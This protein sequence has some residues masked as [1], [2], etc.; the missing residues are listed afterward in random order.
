MSSRTVAPVISPMASMA[1]ST[2]VSTASGVTPSCRLLK[3]PKHG[4]VGPADGVEL[5]GV[6]ENGAVAGR[7]VFKHGVN[8]VRKLVKPRPGFRADGNDIQ[9]GQFPGSTA[10]PRSVLLM[11]ATAFSCSMQRSMM[12]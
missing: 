3:S 10:L 1:C 9:E 12:T 2:S 11:S 7:F 4:F 8:G 6:G 5:P